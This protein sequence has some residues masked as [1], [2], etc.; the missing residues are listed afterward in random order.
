[1]TQWQ[2]APLITWDGWRARLAALTR[3]GIRGC[4]RRLA[5]I[6]QCRSCTM[7]GPYAFGSSIGFSLSVFRLLGLIKLLLNLV[8]C[9]LS[10][11]VRL[12]SQFQRDALRP[13]TRVRRHITRRASSA[14]ASHA[15][16]S[17]GTTPRKPTDNHHLP[18]GNGG[19]R[20]AE[21]FSLYKLPY[22]VLYQ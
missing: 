21:T 18:D 14:A 22:V 19:R 11:H 16:G 7:V 15:T 5:R 10:A 3:S 8:N 6:R 13:R 1:M 12:R 20:D 2:R 17:R 4:L 9:R